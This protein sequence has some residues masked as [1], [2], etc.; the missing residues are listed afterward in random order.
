MIK[1]NIEVNLIKNQKMK[2]RKRMRVVILMEF[3]RNYH[4]G[5]SG[6]MGYL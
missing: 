6:E 5:I 4:L 1:E 3:S 2:A